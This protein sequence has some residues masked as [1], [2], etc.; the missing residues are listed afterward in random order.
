MHFDFHLS[1]EKVGGAEAIG[2]IRNKGGKSVTFVQFSRKSVTE[3]K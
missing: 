1:Q 3:T 2:N